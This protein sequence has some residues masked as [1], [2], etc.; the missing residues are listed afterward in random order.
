MSK[1][2]LCSGSL[3]ILSCLELGAG[4]PLGQLGGEGL[5]VENIETYVSEHEEGAVRGNNAIGS[6]RLSRLL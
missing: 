4:K 2:I 1:R 5:L 6:L 3:F